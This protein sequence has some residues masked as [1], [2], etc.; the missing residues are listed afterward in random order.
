MQT[1]VL[2]S[3]GS[4]EAAR[5]ALLFLPAMCRDPG[6]AATAEAPQ[7]VLPAPGRGG[8]VLC[9][10]APA[11]TPRGRGSLPRQ[12]WLGAAPWLFAEGQ[13]GNRQARRSGRR[14]M[15][16]NG[17]P[18]PAGAAALPAISAQPS[19]GAPRSAAAAAPPPARPGPRPEPRR[20]G[21]G[22][23]RRARQRPS[24]GPGTGGPPSPA[25][26]RQCAGRPREEGPP[27][28]GGR[29]AA[30]ATRSRRR[31]QPRGGRATGLLPRRACRLSPTSVSGY[32]P[33]PASDM[34]VVAL[35]R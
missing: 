29:A 28:G 14:A 21:R 6:S 30:A 1:E 10:A 24:P 20:P 27:R 18:G 3:P 7:R 23:A 17:R 26:R 35:I 32:R 11:G 16:S 33:R 34:R 8:A 13:K 22:S 12:Q 25:V 4:R 19:I 5:S 9:P 2:S 15:P 31:A